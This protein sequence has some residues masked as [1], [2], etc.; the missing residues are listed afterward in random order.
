L[1]VS[2][3]TCFERAPFPGQAIEGLN[4]D[5]GRNVKPF[6]ESGEVSNLEQ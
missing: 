2:M 5:N 4:L 1:T 3:S 6:Q